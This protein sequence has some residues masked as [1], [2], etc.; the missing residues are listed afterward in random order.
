MWIRTPKSSL[1]TPK[2]FFL[3]ILSFCSYN[4]CQQ[5]TFK[6]VT[7]VPPHVKSHQFLIFL[8]ET[9]CTHWSDYCILTFTFIEREVNQ[10]KMFTRG[11]LQDSIFLYARLGQITIEELYWMCSYRHLHTAYYNRRVKILIRILSN[12]FLLQMLQCKNRNWPKKLNVILKALQKLPLERK[13]RHW[14]EKHKTA[15]YF[16]LI[17]IS[18]NMQPLS[19]VLSYHELMWSLTFLELIC[20]Q[21]LLISL[22]SFNYYYKGMFQKLT[23]HQLGMGS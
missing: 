7:R 17:C 2:I 11:M 8:Q 9:T 10:L 4:Y 5:T 18:K 22:L 21:P 13:L 1:Y 14:M 12:K 15:T 19:W 6:F 3:L 16:K 20:L 23:Q